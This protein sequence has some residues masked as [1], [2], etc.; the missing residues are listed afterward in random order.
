[1]DTKKE[2]VQGIINGNQRAFK[3]VFLRHYE[4]LCNFC[5]RYTRSKAISEDLVQEAFSDLWDLRETLDPDKKLRVYL[6]QA[7][8]NKAYDYL[9]H[10]K[11]V[12]RYEADQSHGPKKVAHQ[13]KI[14]QEDKTF[15]KAARR[16]IADLPPRAR[17]TYLLHREDGLTYREIAEVMDI[18]VKTVESQMSRALDI[19]RGR[20]RN[21][22]PAQVTSRTIAKIF[23]IQQTGT[24]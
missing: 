9:A 20:L 6:Y 13:K 4:P 15:I 8:K 14:T 12:R 17:Q 21:D 16:A 1:M 5:W 7:V 3:A 18:T 22:F 19:L 24:D 11:V 10:Q 2:Y 23:S